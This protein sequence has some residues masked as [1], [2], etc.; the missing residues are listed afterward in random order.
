M[1]SREKKN[2]LLWV[3]QLERIQSL[4]A[5]HAPERFHEVRQIREPTVSDQLSVS[6]ICWYIGI[7]VKAHIG[8]SLD[9]TVVITTMQ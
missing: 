7:S 9:Y 1:M 6:Q 4:V 3:I 8:A 5:A 2:S